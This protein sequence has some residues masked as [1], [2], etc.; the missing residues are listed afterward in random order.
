MMRLPVRD[1]K[2]RGFITG[3]KFAKLLT[4]SYGRLVISMRA[5]EVV[6]LH[7]FVKKTQKTPARDI[8]IAR[9][10]VREVRSRS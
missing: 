3:E 7:G 1:S 4:W 10:R 5:C 8:A 6:I 2:I 9:A